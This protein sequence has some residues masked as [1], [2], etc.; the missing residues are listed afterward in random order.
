MSDMKTYIY[1]NEVINF[2]HLFHQKKLCFLHSLL[3]S[4]I[5]QNKHDVPGLH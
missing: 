2:E 5:L 4:V 1:Y 3:Y